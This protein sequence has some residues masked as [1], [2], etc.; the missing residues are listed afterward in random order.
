MK[1]CGCGSRVGIRNDRREPSMIKVQT[2]VVKYVKQ[3]IMQ[4]K[5]KYAEVPERPQTSSEK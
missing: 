5:H 1:M 3:L 2:E 4:L